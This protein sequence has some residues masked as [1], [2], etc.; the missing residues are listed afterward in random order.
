MLGLQDPDVFGWQ[1]TL[2][3]AR[4][5]LID[6][7]QERDGEADVAT[8][9]AGRLGDIDRDLCLAAA[10]WKL[11]HDPGDAPSARFSQFLHRVG[12]V[13]PRCE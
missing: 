4:D 6:E 11:K 2:L 13:E 8:L 7:S 10:G 5:G 3:E 9:A 1:A 12:L